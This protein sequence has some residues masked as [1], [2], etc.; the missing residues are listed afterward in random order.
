[1]KLETGVVIGVR[2]LFAFAMLAGGV[3]A[4]APR[5]DIDG[6]TDA[7]TPILAEQLHWT[8]PPSVPGLR[9]AWV[10]GGEREPGPYTLRVKLASGSRVPPHTHPDQRVCTVLAGTVYVAFGENPDE[11]KGAAMPTGAVYVLPA[12][13]PHYVWTRDGDASYQETGIAP[14]ATVFLSPA[15]SGQQAP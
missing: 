9:M 10:Q 8:G 14:T 1:M 7:P 11:T 3:A 12:N 5:A 4:S 13:V 15:A 6:H 2:R